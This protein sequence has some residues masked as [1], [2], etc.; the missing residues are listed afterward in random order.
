MILLLVGVFGNTTFSGRILSLAETSRNFSRSK[1]EVAALEK[2]RADVMA[3]FSALIEPRLLRRDDAARYV[4]GDV[5]L[6]LFVRAG[7]LK[8]IVQRKR[9]TLYQRSDLDGCCGRL[10]AGEFPEAEKVRDRSEKAFSM[11]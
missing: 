7:C 3:K 9:L 5:M 1:G 10:G 8:P 4:G 6:N 11:P 2:V